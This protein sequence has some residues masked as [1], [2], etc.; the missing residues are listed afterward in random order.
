MARILTL[1]LEHRYTDHMDRLRTEGWEHS[2]GDG[3]RDA[4]DDASWHLVA[5]VGARPVG[6]VRLTPGDTSVLQSWSGG[7]APLPTGRHVIELTRGVV[8]H[9]F[10]GLGIYR[11]LMLEAMLRLRGLG[12]RVATA[13]IEPEFFARGFLHGLGFRNVGMPL[14]FRDTPRPATLAQCIQ[15]SVSRPRESLWQTMWARQGASA[16]E[17]GW[18]TDSELTV[19]AA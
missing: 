9:S 5:R 12:S 17:L 14:I 11:L 13:S 15:V 7:V 16:A 4:F 3:A 2:V 6:M 1:R 19:D 18:A 10:R 8:D